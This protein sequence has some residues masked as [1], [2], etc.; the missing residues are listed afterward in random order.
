MPRPVTLLARTAASHEQEK[1]PHADTT[2]GALFLTGKVTGK[3]TGRA[4]RTT[5]IRIPTRTRRT[6]MTDMRA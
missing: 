1:P 5:K 6:T 3:V 4:T 2:L